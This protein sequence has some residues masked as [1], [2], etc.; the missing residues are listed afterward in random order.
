MKAIVLENNIVPHL[1]GEVVT[2][3]DVVHRQWVWIECESSGL[4]TI[5]KHYLR[6][7]DV[8][9]SARA[10][11]INT[12]NVGGLSARANGRVYGPVSG[13]TR[14]LLENGIWRWERA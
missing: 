1:A 5:P 8:K 14:A 10:I 7:I 9:D 2:Y 3:H 6:M 11:E 13:D 4:W 12:V